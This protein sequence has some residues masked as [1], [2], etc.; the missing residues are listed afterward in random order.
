MRVAGCALCL[1]MMCI[2]A[3]IIEVELHTFHFSNYTRNRLNLPAEH[4]TLPCV[5][6]ILKCMHVS[7][8]YTFAHMVSMQM[9]SSCISYYAPVRDDPDNKLVPDPDA[10]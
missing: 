1:Q 3:W 2:C 9:Q 7:T 5:P 6:L 4:F 10:P 8:Y